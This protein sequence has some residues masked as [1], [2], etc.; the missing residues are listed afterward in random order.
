MNLEAFFRDNEDWRKYSDLVALPPL[1]EEMMSEFSDICPEVLARCMEFVNEGGGSVTRGA[2]YLRVRREDKREAGDKWASMLAL[3]AFPG[4][5]TT[6]TFWGGRKPW[7]ELYTAD[8]AANVKKKLAENG[9]NIKAG[10]EYMPELARFVGD[11]E[12]VVPFGGARSYIKKLCETRGWAATGAVNVKHREPD[13]DLLAN[14]NCPL[15]E[16]VIRQKTSD[17][18]R[19]DPSL[20]KLHRQEMRE[21]VLEKFGPSR[22]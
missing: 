13:A 22:S 21:K 2:V 12:A 9:F 17:L 20:K 10:D 8:Y 19:L 14:E 15:S 4:I 5:Q 3:N 7:H 18:V 1:P 6:D 11:P 16:K